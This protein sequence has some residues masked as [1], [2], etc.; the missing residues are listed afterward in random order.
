[1]DG[2][3]KEYCKERAKERGTSLSNFVLSLIRKHRKNYN[4][5]GR[6]KKLIDRK[7]QNGAGV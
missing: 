7:S 5:N 3:Y 1:M 6:R 2:I 4:R